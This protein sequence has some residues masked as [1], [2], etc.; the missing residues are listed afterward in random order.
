MAV[1]ESARS[2]TE[3]VAALEALGASDSARFDEALARFYEQWKAN[4]LVIDKWFSIQAAA[5]RSDSLDRVRRLRAHADFNLR[6]PNRVR[7]LASAFAMR[8]PRAFHAASGE[9][10]RFVATLAEDIDALNP[11]LAA[12]LLTSF[13]S[14]RRFDPGR[15][16]HA[17]AALEALA[18]LPHL[19]KN[20]R[21]MVERALA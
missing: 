16:S 21:E 12:R 8:N 15:Q 20:T 5:P 2:M 3:K 19:S 13:E 4:P 1:F 9:G 11:A 14:W 6:N 17:R 10:Y 7:A 18:A